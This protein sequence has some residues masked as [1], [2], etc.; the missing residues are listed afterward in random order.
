MSGHEYDVGGAVT[1]VAEY[2]VEHVLEPGRLREMRDF[3]FQPDIGARAF[4]QLVGDYRCVVAI[5]LQG[6]PV[7]CSIHSM[8]ESMSS[9]QQ[10]SEYGGAA[11]RVLVLPA[12]GAVLDAEHRV[13]FGGR[14]DARPV[15][16]DVE[17]FQ[18]FAIA[19]FDHL[20]LLPA[21]VL[22]RP[23]VRLFQPRDLRGMFPGL[24]RQGVRM[25]RD[26]L[27][28][29]RGQQFGSCVVVRLHFRRPPGPWRPALAALP[30]APASTQFRIPPTGVR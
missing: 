22:D 26:S 10:R 20:L 3:G 14:I 16:G 24:H 17:L 29:L 6:L 25:A 21:R 12:L 2:G 8:T 11:G 30:P 23:V 7:Q 9:I 13:Y 19:L 1:G 15:I 18:R 4:D 27:N 5:A 28:D